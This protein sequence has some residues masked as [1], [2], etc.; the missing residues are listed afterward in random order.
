[1]PTVGKPT[2]PPRKNSRRNGRPAPSVTPRTIAHP[3]IDVKLFL[4][5]E[6][7]LI[8]ADYAKELLG[9]RVTTERGEAQFEDMAG[10]MIVCD[11]NL[12]NRP[13]DR[14]TA[15]SYA[16]D[17]LNRHWADSRNTKPDDTEPMTLNGETIIIDRYGDVDSGQHRLIG[18]VFAT[19][20]WEGLGALGK[21]QKAHWRGLWPEAPSMEGIVVF[22]V[23]S[24]P[25]VKRTLD[26]VRPRDLG[27]VLYTSGIAVDKKPAERERLTR[28]LAYALR[29][30][31]YRV[32]G[33]LDSFNPAHTH[34]QMLDLLERHGGDTG[35]LVQAV[36]HIT[37][38]DVM[39]KDREGRPIPNAR[40]KLSRYVPPGTASALLYLMGCSKSSSDDYRNADPPNDSVL[41]WDT[42][43]RALEFW[44]ELA[45]CTAQGF[46][47]IRAAF[48]GLVD[49]ET[50]EGGGTPAERQAILAKAWTC[51]VSNDK[52]LEKDVTLGDELY[53]IHKD[54][55]G[56]VLS[57]HLVVHPPFGGID[58]GEPEEREEPGES[59]EP[60]E[61]ELELQGPQ[62]GVRT[63]T[64]DPAEEREARRQL[65]LAGQIAELKRQH[66]DKLL[67]FR[68]A[69][70]YGAWGE[71]AE[72]LKKVL[73]ADLKKIS[74]V[75]YTEFK[76]KNLAGNLLKLLKVG[77]KVALCEQTADG[78]T[79]VKDYEPPTNGD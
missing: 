24:N 26:N 20:L 18:L 17:Q 75:L 1:M 25:R 14:K 41:N 31:W 23:S 43:G 56:N 40:R 32:W 47:E 6:G 2:K 72:I 46:K 15:L 48:N 77:H 63:E 4:A 38:E 71:D 30:L 60:G 70:A 28:T 52:I 33:N 74:G 67:V 12:H 64:D 22:G 58:G 42:W 49:P 79:V 29:Y 36:K 73:K 45:K 35:R 53:Q 66:P 62:G 19:Q 69:G 3:E 37:D 5:E 13:F 65:D 57:K 39:P 7:N 68:R 27:D 51:W 16:Q 44:T 34:S 76:A 9:W 21:K 54:A 8:T 78:E 59:R 10:D 55:E 61:E 11:H 50:G